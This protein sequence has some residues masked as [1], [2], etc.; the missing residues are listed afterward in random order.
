M[1]RTRLTASERSEQLV[2][3]A[4]T[5]FST[6]GYAGTSTDDVAR[7]AGV[8]QPYVIRLFGSK[9][10]LFIATVEHAAGRIEQAFQRAAERQPDLASLRIAY[11][12]LLVERDLLAVLL[13][14]FA[15]SSEPAIGFA[16]RVCYGRIYQLVRD[17]TGATAQETREFLATGMLLTV[18]AS[19]HVIGPDAVAP[20]PW[21]SELAETIYKPE[22]GPEP[23]AGDAAEEERPG[24]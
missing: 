4:V 5:A 19:I 18:L 8:S 1:T 17:L 9:Q 20:E 14:G 15:A 3:A 23:E 16:V 11:D 10:R 21:M 12:E 6:A 13:H 2:A 22:P 24:G 7:L